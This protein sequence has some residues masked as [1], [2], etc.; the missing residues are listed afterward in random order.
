MVSLL[1]GMKDIPV[2]AVAADAKP[3]EDTAAMAAAYGLDTPT[4]VL[5]VLPNPCNVRAIIFGCDLPL[6]K[7]REARTF[8]ISRHADPATGKGAWFGMEL[9][10]S[11]V[12]RLNTKF[13]RLVSCA[14]PSGRAATSPRFPSPPCAASPSATSRPLVMDY[15]HIGEAWT[16]KLGD[17]DVTPNINIHRAEYYLRSL[18]QLKV[19]Q[20]LDSTD[21][22]A[23]KALEKPVFS[24]KVEMEIADTSAADRALM[25]D[26]HPQ[27]ETTDGTPEEL[28]N[29][30][31][32]EDPFG[33]PVAA[34][35]KTHRETR[36]IEIVP[37]DNTSDTPFFYG[38]LRE[39][40]ELFIL[41]FEDAQGL[42]GDMLDL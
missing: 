38:R 22:D 30:A 25:D 4:Y 19:S 11:S 7:D 41:R 39:T 23:L 29:A 1:R 12:Y 5:S 36:T 8:L 21:E 40:G 24:V 28:L 15:D 13:T 34:A 37:G 31:S 35:P 14:P 32:E 10:G 17:K 3:G 16:G 20:W 2:D 9:G 27:V 26:T 6:V 42:A 33:E 18:Q